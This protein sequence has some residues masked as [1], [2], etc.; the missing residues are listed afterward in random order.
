MGCL[1]MGNC[2]GLPVILLTKTIAIFAIVVGFY[3]YKNP[4]KAIGGQIAFYRKI[5]WRMEPVDMAR[6]IRN[7]RTMGF[8]AL[9]CGV[10][11]FLILIL[12]K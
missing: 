11:T 12:K 2:T 9:F 6:E 10:G 7:T 3:L 5:N 1:L 8:F 4:Q